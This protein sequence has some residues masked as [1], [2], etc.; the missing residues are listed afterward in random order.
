MICAS[1]FCASARI[2]SRDRSRPVN[3][4]SAA[5][6]AIIRAEE[7]AMPAPAGDCEWVSRRKPPSGAKQRTNSAARRWRNVFA[8]ASASRSAK[9]SSLPVS[10]DFKWMALPSP[11][12]MRQVV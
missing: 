12:V 8:R 3:C 5:V 6:V 11:G 7:P 1:T 4:A 9:R 2:S 10:A